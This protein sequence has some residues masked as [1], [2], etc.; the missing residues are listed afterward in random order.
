M[1][2]PDPIDG[3]YQ[4]PDQSEPQPQRRPRRGGWGTIAAGGAVL[5]AKFK[6]FLALLL[7]AKFLLLGLK[8][9][10]SSW[11]FLLSLWFYVAVFGWQLG[12]VLVL[13]LAAHEFGH[14]MAYKNYGLAVRAP[15]FVPFMGAFTA[16]AVA[17]DL[18]QDAYIA[19]AGPLTGLVLA[20]ACYALGIANGERFWFACA[21]LAAFLNL[22]NMLPVL[23]FDGGRVIGAV[24][25]PLWIAGVVL[26]V[27]AAVWLHLPIFFV[28]ILALLGLPSMIAAFRGAPDPRAAAMSFAARARVSVWYVAV[29]LALLAVL[30]GAQAHLPA[31]ASGL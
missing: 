8:L 25:P 30:G 26:F 15:V 7:Q 9:L 21:D 29:S 11:T 19:L 23:P 4:P 20:G 22:F 5:L 31:N 27:A 3:E 28:V 14:Y 13:V 2:E 24:W 6:A 10:G 17:P 12:I 16:G 1:H 18:E